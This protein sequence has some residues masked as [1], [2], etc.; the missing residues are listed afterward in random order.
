MTAQPQP[1]PAFDGRAFRSALGTFPTG[2]VVVAA[3]VDGRPTGLAVNSFTS[4]SLA[5]PLVA[6]CADQGSST[7]PDLRRAGAFSVS[8]L[9]ADQGEL[10]RRF[11]AKGTDRFSQVEWTPGA[12]GHPRIAGAVTWLDCRIHALLPGGDHE[13]VLGEVVDL[14]TREAEPL[15]FHRGRFARLEA[16]ASE[17]DA[18]EPEESALYDLHGLDVAAPFFDVLVSRLR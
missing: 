7:W 9:A 3:V 4:V 1:A 13:I 11:A 15:A 10:C 12:D 5:P 14:A 6:F 2:V 17:P 8:V 16:P 18:R